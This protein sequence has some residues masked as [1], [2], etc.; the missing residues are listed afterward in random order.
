LFVFRRRDPAGGS[1]RAPGHPW[2]T[3]FFVLACAATVA[4]TIWNNP[5]NSAI[6]FG[7]LLAGVP[8]CLFWLRRR[9][10]A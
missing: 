10:R 9:N 6:G 1:F 4:G 8:V 3:L 2:T 5:I 7:I